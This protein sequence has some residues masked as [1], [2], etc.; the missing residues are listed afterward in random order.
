MQHEF[1]FSDIHSTFSLYASNGSMKTSF[2]KTFEYISKEEQPKDLVYSDR[3]AEWDIN[4]DNNSI[5]PSQI[6]VIHSYKKDYESKKIST[7]MVNKQLRTA[8]ES[9]H[10]NI[11]DKK[12]ISYMSTATATTSWRLCSGSMDNNVVADSVVLSATT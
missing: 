2:A 8:Y 9:I 4:L 3:I 11:D 6:F 5:K 12:K 7:L 1:E 10:K